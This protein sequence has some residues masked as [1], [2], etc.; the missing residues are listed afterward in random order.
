VPTRSSRPWVGGKGGSALA[1]AGLPCAPCTGGHTPAVCWRLCVD[2]RT[3]TTAVASGRCAGRHRHWGVFAVG[4]RHRVGSRRGTAHQRGARAVHGA[5]RHSSSLRYAHAVAVPRA[6]R[7]A[8]GPAEATDRP[9]GAEPGLARAARHGVSTAC[10]TVGRG[11]VGMAAAARTCAMCAWRL[12]CHAGPSRGLRPA[13]AGRAY[14]AM[15]PFN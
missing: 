15:V 6:R 10:S 1:R 14:A 2:R 13:R 9:H 7:G 11:C 12:C 4:H 3:V 5:A 8:G